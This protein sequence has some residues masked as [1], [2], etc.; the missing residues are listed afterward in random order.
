MCQDLAFPL[1]YIASTYKKGNFGGGKRQK[2]LRNGK[3]E[4]LHQFEEGLAI[5][6]MCCF[7][8]ALQGEYYLELSL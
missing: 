6:L 5:L 3:P 1:F 4:K 7:E 2:T 8:F